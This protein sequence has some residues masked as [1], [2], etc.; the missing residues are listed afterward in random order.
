MFSTAARVVTGLALVAVALLA[1]ARSSWAADVIIAPGAE[2]TLTGDIVLSGSD[3]FQAGDPAGPRCKIHGGSHAIS[4]DTSWNATFTMNNCDVDA[5]GVA[6]SPALSVATA[7]SV[8]I[9]GSTFSTSSQ[10]LI[11]S[12]GDMSV[13]FNNNTIA[14]DSIVTVDMTSLDNSQDAFH[15]T[16]GST[17]TKV[18]QGNRILRSRATFDLTD[19]WLIGGDTPAQGNVFAG[20]RGGIFISRTGPMTIRGNYSHPLGAG[21]NQVK[22]L[23]IFNPGGGDTIIEHNVFVGNDWN[24]E[25]NTPGEIRYNLVVNPHE[26]GWIRAYSESGLKVHHNL[27]VQTADNQYDANQGGFVVLNIYDTTMPTGPLEI[28]NNTIDSGGDCNPGNAGG[29][30]MADPIGSLRS[31]A[32]LNFRLAPWAG[33]ALIGTSAKTVPN[34]LPAL[35]GYADYNLFNNPDPTVQAN[36]NVGVAGKTLRVDPGFA[37]HDVPVGGAVNAQTA[38]KL[39]NPI[40]RLF[41]YGDGMITGESALSMADQMVAA[42]TLTVCQIL[43]Y[44]RQAYTPAADSPLVDAG[45][46][47]EGA[48]N[49]IGAIGAGADNSLD[50]FGKLCD[51]TDVGAPLTS[52]NIFKCNTVP[53]VPGGGSTG[54]GGSSPVQTGPHNFVCVCQSA[55]GAGS[56]WAAAALIAGATA[57]T[58]RRRRRR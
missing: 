17:G 3:L 11:T 54:A 25:V 1:S 50:L 53:I 16:G 14:E 44:Y 4:T 47:Q 31:N 19:S 15:A 58:A 38:P 29:A 7:H 55:G 34:P 39:A 6:G 57:L 8:T 23:S 9:V 13:T 20:F 48:G 52:D 18:F 35:L 12:S 56:P 46:P 43:A 40:P 41:P 26:R 42:G 28:Y 30:M 27:L 10:I 21:W 51:P 45:D 36:Y 37:Y 24:I 22:N 5:L 49:D 32:F 33:T 2:Y